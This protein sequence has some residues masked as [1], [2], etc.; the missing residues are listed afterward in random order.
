MVKKCGD[1]FSICKYFEG[2]II[3]NLL[4]SL[5]LPGRRSPGELRMD[6][7]LCRQFT[8]FLKVMNGIANRPRS[9]VMMSKMIWRDIKWK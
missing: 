3:Q 7:G 4:N 1:D 2:D 6:C 8:D 5:H 9:L